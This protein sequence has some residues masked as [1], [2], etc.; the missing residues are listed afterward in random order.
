VVDGVFRDGHGPYRFVLDTGQQG[1]QVDAKVAHQLGL[2]PTGRVKLASITGTTDALLAVVRE[3]SLGP[4]TAS[5]QEVVFASLEGTTGLGG[6]DGILGQEFLAHFD[7]LLDFSNNWLVLG[8]PP[9]PGGS[10]VPFE[11]I[12]GRPAIKTSEGKLVID[13][14]SNVTILYR[15]S[16]SAHNGTTL[17][18]SSGKRFIPQARDLRLRIAGREYYARVASTPSSLNEDGVLQATLFH[19]V[20]VSNS[21][22]YVILD[23]QANGRA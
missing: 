10:Q 18:T 23:P 13:S 16:L 7:Y 5:D 1:N 21:G 6:I 20:F 8:G 9:P 22:K 11:S 17:S 19:A 15:S 3:I 14:G 2:A 12:D 4:A